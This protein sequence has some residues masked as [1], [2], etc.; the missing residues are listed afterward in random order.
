MSTFN[1]E[2]V[3]TGDRDAA[4]GHVKEALEGEGFQIHEEHH[5]TWK[6]V[7]HADAA[8]IFGGA[9]AGDEHQRQIFEVAFADEGDGLLVRL[10]RPVQWGDAQA[11]EF[12]RLEDTYSKTEAR[13]AQRLLA[14]GLLARSSV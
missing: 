7:H 5:G 8:G 4:R 10:H 2:F 6:A 12:A 13:I 14:T 1:A 11:L 9:L 3:L